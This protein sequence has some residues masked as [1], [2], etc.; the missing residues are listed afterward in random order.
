MIKIIIEFPTF[1]AR[2]TSVPTWT[3]PF[4]KSSNIT[5]TLSMLLKISGL[6]PECSQQSPITLFVAGHQSNSSSTLISSNIQTTLVTSL[7]DGVSIQYVAAIFMVSCSIVGNIGVAWSDV[8]QGCQV[9][10]RPGMLVDSW[11]N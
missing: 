2:H 11:G 8:M 1:Y 5:C 9:L 3:L 10:D 7:L 6:R 4:T